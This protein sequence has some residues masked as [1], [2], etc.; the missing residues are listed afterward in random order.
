MALHRSRPSARRAALPAVVT[1]A[2]LLAVAGL[3]AA[4]VGAASAAP[5]TWTPS[6]AT[7][8]A[9]GAAAAFSAPNDVRYTHSGALLVADFAG[10]GVLRRDTD[11][12]WSVVAP[13]GTDDRSM[14]N[15]SA[16]AESD[17]GRLI[18]A[19]AGRRP[20]PGGPGTIAVLDGHD[21]ERRFAAPSDR[22]VSELAVDGTRLVAAVAGSGS[23]WETD[24][25]A[26]IPVWRA[27]DGPWVDP[28][29]VAVSPDGSVLIV[30]DG[31]TDVVWRLDR[32]TGVT[33]SLGTVQDDQGRVRL[34]GVALL[35]EGSVVVAD[36]GGGRV[37]VRQDGEWTV[38]FAGAPDGTTLANP[39]GVSVGPGDRIAV[40]D[41]NR[42]RVVEAERTPTGTPTPDVTS[43]PTPDVTS[44]PTPDVTPAPTPVVTSAPAPDV[45]PAPTPTPVVTSGP[46][47]D[48]TSTPTPSPGAGQPSATPTAGATP[49]PS[50]PA[51]TTPTATPSPSAPSTSPPAVTPTPTWTPTPTPSAST[52]QGPL[53]PGS[54]TSAGNGGNSG[55]TGGHTRP[56]A[57]TDASTAPP[58]SATNARTLASTGAGP[59]GALA[60]AAATAVLAGILL[61]ST[62]RRHRHRR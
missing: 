41:Y 15:P 52:S 40:A 16:L 35:G 3:G 19:E 32:S 5:A 56:R 51:T 62:T 49:T 14:W 54:T 48:A 36:N 31:A 58:R 44:A 38:A 39:T 7:T 23:L 59:V 26:D 25:A 55:G 30:A 4:T 8:D 33:S 21:V 57:G 37:F 22:A 1:A 27:V 28:A 6:A 13:F 18:V 11:G 50:A 20:T 60:L 45:T 2:A 24:T 12:T 10:N 47:P 42:R 53:D 46:T 9:P 29:G 61:R 17:D 34:R 43:A